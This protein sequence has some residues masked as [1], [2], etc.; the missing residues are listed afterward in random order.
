MHRYDDWEYEGLCDIVI[1]P[2]NTDGTVLEVEYGAKGKTVT[3][4]EADLDAL[5]DA[6]IVHKLASVAVTNPTFLDLYL[7][8]EYVGFGE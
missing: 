5:V 7:W 6:A 8:F 2:K 1:T 4:T 3:I